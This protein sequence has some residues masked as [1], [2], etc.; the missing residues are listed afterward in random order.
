MRD[1]DCLSLKIYF[2]EIQKFKMMKDSHPHPAFS[3]HDG[4][5]Q[6]PEVPRV[7]QFEVTWLGHEVL[8]LP[9]GGLS[10]GR[11][12]QTVDGLAGQEIHTFVAPFV[13]LRRWPGRHVALNTTFDMPYF[14]FLWL[15]SGSF[16][17]D[18]NH[19][20]AFIHFNPLLK[21]FKTSLCSQ[22]LMSIKNGPL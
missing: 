9:L 7:A 11:G 22:V 3:C 10:S 19:K 17:I 4:F 12:L 18:I 16:F 2:K 6:I 8:N 21:H 20:W 14:Q 5:K 15:L 1:C 13:G